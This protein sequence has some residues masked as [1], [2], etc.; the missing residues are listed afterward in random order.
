MME[1]G[2]E[3]MQATYRHNYERLAAIKQKYDSKNFFR[4]NQNLHPQAVAK[5]S[6]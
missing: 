5:G 1:E 6:A 2:Q 4:V 3:R